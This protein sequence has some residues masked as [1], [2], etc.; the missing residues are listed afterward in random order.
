MNDRLRRVRVSAALCTALATVLLAAAAATAHA[1]LPT[2]TVTLD[3]STVTVA[4]ASQS[5]AVNVISVA[6]GVKEASAILLLLRPGVTPADVYAALADEAMQDPN[7]LTRLGAIVFDAEAAPGQGSEAQIDL[8][9]GQYVALS[10]IG[11]NAPKA[12][13]SF[14]VT[15]GAAPVALPPPEATMRTIDFMFKGPRT[16]RDGE[17]V[18]FENEGFVVHMDVAFPVRSHRT[19]N[20]FA[21]GLLAG[22]AQNAFKLATGPPVVFAGPLAT[23]SAQQETIT[24]KPGWYVQACFMNTQDGRGHTLLGMERV[25]KITR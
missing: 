9:P 1:T 8:Q 12:H 18:R 24:A 10:A 4:G 14:T 11:E 19:A 16:L 25:I 7:S 15:A 23:G 3:A 21:A 2:L 22:K 5:G 13:T 20:K 6:T 17:L